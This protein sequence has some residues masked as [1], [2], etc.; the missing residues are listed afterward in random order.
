MIAIA[1]KNLIVSGS[2]QNNPEQTLYRSRETTYINIMNIIHYC[3]EFCPIGPKDDEVIS[4]LI[5][6]ACPSNTSISGF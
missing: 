1:E 5:W 6:L 3:N 2:A 4:W